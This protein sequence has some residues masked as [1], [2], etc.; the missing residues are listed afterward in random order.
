VNLSVLVAL[1]LL[2]ASQQPDYPIDSFRLPVLSQPSEGRVTFADVSFT[3]A[4]TD[5]TSPTLGARLHVRDWGFLEAHVGRDRGGVSATTDRLEMGIEEERGRYDVR[6][7]YRGSRYRI[8][9]DA[10]RRRDDQ[11]SGWVRG[12][13]GAFRVNPD[14][15]VFAGLQGDSDD[16][17]LGLPERRLAT[18]RI[19][20]LYQRGTHLDALVEGVKFRSLTAGGLELEGDAITASGLAIVFGA[21]WRG[22]WNY[23]WVEGRLGR[24]RAFVALETIV[25]VPRFENFVL[26]GRTGQRW[27]PKLGRF[28][29]QWRFGVAFHGRRYRLSRQGAAAE[30]MLRLS[31]RLVGLGLNERRVYDDDARRAFRE[32]LSLSPARDELRGE[33]EGLHANQIAERNVPL[34]G[35][36]FEQEHDQLEGRRTRT[37]RALVGI[38]WPLSWPYRRDERAVRFITLRLA[39]TSRQ[40][41]S[42][43]RSRQLQATIDVALNRETSIVVRWSEAERLPVHAALSGGPSPLI[44]LQYVYSYGK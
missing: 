9:V 12:V 4:D 21:E 8:R 38:P 36:E 1:G 34:L 35:F 30:R 24:E 25:P 6:A 18:Q 7:G 16:V 19:G 32:R 31:R 42:S 3:V 13:V 26:S 27:E 40:F 2:F 29:H 43:Y 44:E 39:H 28:E 5:R 14:M 15:E 11:G 10:F 20:L 23:E 22:E 37:Y 33:I 17:T 41:D